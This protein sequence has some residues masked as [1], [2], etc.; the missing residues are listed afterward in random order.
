M[1]GAGDKAHV[2]GCRARMGRSRPFDG[3]GADRRD[4]ADREAPGCR[5]AEEREI[6]GGRA[7]GLGKIDKERTLPG[8]GGHPAADGAGGDP[9]TRELLEMGSL[10]GTGDVSG[11]AGVEQQGHGAGLFGLTRDE[12]A[13]VD[14]GA[15]QIGYAVEVP[16]ESTLRPPGVMSHD[17]S[18]S[19]E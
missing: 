10:Q 13:R 15:M 9:D 11:C 18:I 3:S 17:P 6:R 19:E 4:I 16:T 1:V 2:P 5:G 12:S 7:R 8:A 14:E